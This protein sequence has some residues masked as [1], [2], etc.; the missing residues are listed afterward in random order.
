MEGPMKRLFL[1]LGFIIIVSGCTIEF[2]TGAEKTQD[3]PD[4]ILGDFKYISAD[5]SGK[6]EWELRAREA[7]MYNVKNEVYLYNMAITFFN[8]SN[9]VKSFVS[10]NSGYVDKLTM[11]I[12]CQGKVKILSENQATLEADKVYWDNKK[13]LFYS[14]PEELVVLKR[15]NTVIAGYK[16]VADAGLKE[17]TIEKVR[18][19]IKK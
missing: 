4:F 17:V 15:G 8:E 7:K 16:M 6:R 14:Q 19:N 5:N 1:F 11:S 3:F 12:F 18:A 13:K 10:A 2:K 9:Y